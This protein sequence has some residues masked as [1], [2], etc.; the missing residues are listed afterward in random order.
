MSQEQVA[1]R[2]G[3]SRPAVRTRFVCCNPGAGSGDDRQWD[4]Q[5]RS[6]PRFW[7]S[8]TPSTRLPREKAAGEGWRSVVEDAVRERRAIEEPTAGPRTVTQVRPV[9]IIELEKRLSDRLGS[10]VKIEYKNKKGRWRSGS[11]HWK[12][13]SGFTGIF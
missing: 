10:R 9:E 5:R 3:K 13:W 8:R 7:D 11:P 1:E 12:T 6:R 2:V 4:S